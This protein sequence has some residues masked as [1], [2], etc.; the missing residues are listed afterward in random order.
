MLTKSVTEYEVDPK[1][2]RR[3]Q[4]QF[5]LAHGVIRETTFRLAGLIP[6]YRE[7]KLVERFVY[8]M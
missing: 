1:G 5:F 7:R 4:V 6:V 8:R 2:K 3:D